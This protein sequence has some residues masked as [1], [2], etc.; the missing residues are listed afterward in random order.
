MAQLVDWIIRVQGKRDVP[1]L[2]D[3]ALVWWHDWVERAARRRPGTLSLGEGYEVAPRSVR[4]ATPAGHRV[5]WRESLRPHSNSLVNEASAELGISRTTIFNRLRQGQRH[6]DDFGAA[7]DPFKLLI[8][9]LQE[10]APAGKLEP[11]RRQIV[12]T[13]IEEGMK[14]D[15]A[16]KLERRSRNLPEAQQQERLLAALARLRKSSSPGQ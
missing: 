2:A 12:D 13:L 8:R 1:T 5:Y 16:R 10:Q 7:D 3:D 9:Y 11:E 6:L 15:S 4:P 14:P